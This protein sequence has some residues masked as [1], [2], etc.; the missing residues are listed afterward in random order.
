MKALT[1][2]VRLTSNFQRNKL[3]VTFPCL[4][5]HLATQHCD[6]QDKKG[7][8]IGGILETVRGLKAEGET[9]MGVVWG[10]HLGKELGLQKLYRSRKRARI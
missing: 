5:H 8:G 1:K 7:K 4:G 10:L 9:K 3:W 2:M 6:E